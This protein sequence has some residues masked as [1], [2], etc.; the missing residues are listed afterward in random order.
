VYIKRDNLNLRHENRRL[1]RKVVAF[2]NA[3]MVMVSS[4]DTVEVLLWPQALPIMF[5]YSKSLCAV[6]HLSTIKGP[7]PK[8]MK[9]DIYENR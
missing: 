7:V 6:E 5:G 3:A 4:D 8:F 2:V 1:S 9:G